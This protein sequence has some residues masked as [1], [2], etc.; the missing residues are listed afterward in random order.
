MQKFVSVFSPKRLK[1][2]YDS[3]TKSDTLSQRRYVILLS[4][5]KN[6]RASKI[7]HDYEKRSER[8]KTA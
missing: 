2:S 3:C 7:V 1:N 8:T 5:T 4:S 6:N